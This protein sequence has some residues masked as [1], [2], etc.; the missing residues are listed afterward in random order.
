MRFNRKN[1]IRVFDGHNKSTTIRLK[2]QRIGKHNIWAGSYYHPEKLGTVEVVAV[3]SK[4]FGNL[5]DEDGKLDG[6]DNVHELKAE[7][8]ELNK[9][10]TSVTMV[11]IN[12]IENPIN[13]DKKTTDRL[14]VE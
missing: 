1:W 9:S 2:P 3:K 12:H 14:G 8:L 5:T 4:L 7:L 10:I 11:Y 13:E 6:F